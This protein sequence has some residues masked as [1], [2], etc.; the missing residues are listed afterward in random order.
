V[1]EIAD[2]S[3]EQNGWGIHSCTFVFIM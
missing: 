2:I 3:T 1:V